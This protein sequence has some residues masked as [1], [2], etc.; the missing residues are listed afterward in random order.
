MSEIKK[1]ID[2]IY[3][4][5][6]IKKSSKCTGRRLFLYIKGIIIYLYMFQMVIQPTTYLQYEQS[7]SSFA[8]AGVADLLSAYLNHSIKYEN[9]SNSFSYR[10]IYV[11]LRSATKANA[12]YHLR[13]NV[14]GK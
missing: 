3:E 9:Q 2:N 7:N 5:A 1:G 6:S 14:A 12:S 8:A 10:Y 11:F 4:N 13:N